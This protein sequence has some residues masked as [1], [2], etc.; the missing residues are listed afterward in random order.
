MLRESAE[1]FLGAEF[2]NFYKEHRQISVMAKGDFQA[3]RTSASQIIWTELF[4]RGTQLRENCEIL[5]CG[6][7]ALDLA[8][9]SYLLE[10]P[11]HDLS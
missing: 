8:S 9:R 5:E 3:T 1:S 7:I 2:T 11:S 4:F 10:Q 6:R